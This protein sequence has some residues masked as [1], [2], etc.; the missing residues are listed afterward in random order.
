MQGSDREDPK[1]DGVHPVINPDSPTRSLGSFASTLSSNTC[2]ESVIRA[3]LSPITDPTTLRTFARV[4]EECL[5]CL[6]STNDPL[7]VLPRDV[8]LKI[9][10]YLDPVSL[11]ECL[12]VSRHWSEL[13]KETSL[14][15]NLCTS[16]A[17]YKLSSAEEEREQLLRHTVMD[18]GTTVAW[19][20]VFG[21]RY[22]LQ[23]NWCKGRCVIRTFEGHHQGG[24]RL[25]FL[26]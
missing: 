2:P 6:Y 16:S 13:A 18:G 20:R 14:W 10:S 22:R 26:K 1:V 4:A 3:L 21:E 8:A 15:K 5:R 23:R 12:R 9:L 11:C 17:V 25:Y 7:I 19:R 24:W